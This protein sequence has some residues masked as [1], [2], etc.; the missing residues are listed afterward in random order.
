MK[1]KLLSDM[2]VSDGGVY[3]SSVDIDICYDKYGFPYIPAKRIRGCLREC[4]IELQDWFQIKEKTIRWKKMFGEE[5]CSTNRAAVRINDAHLEGY[6]EM[7]KLA[8]E[9]AG[10][11]VFHP[12]NILNHFTY[13]RT[14]TAINYE[15]GVAD[16]ASLRTMRVADKELVFEAEVDMDQAYK[17]EL[18]SCCAVFHSIGVSRTRG[19][20]EIQVTLEPCDSEQ[21]KVKHEPYEE[22]AEILQYQLFLEEPVICKSVNGGESRTLDYI[23]GSK[24]QGLLIEN[25]DSREEFLK[26][27]NSAELFC[28]NAYISQNHIRCTEVPSYIY[29]VKNDSA[30]YVNKLYPEP[31][32]V[33]EEALQLNAMK[34]CYISFDEKQR[35]HK[36]SVKIE[37]RYH[38]RRPEDKAAGRAA[39]E[40][41]GNS[42][43]YQM[44]SIEAGQSFQGYFA[45][46]PSQIKAIYEILSK[47]DTY[48]IGYSRTSEYGKVRLRITGTKKIEPS[49]PVRAKKFCVKME[50]PVIVYN[51]NAFYSTDPRDLIG[52]VNAVLGISEDI[53]KLLATSEEKQEE[54]SGVRIYARYTMSGGYNTTW[55]CPKP[56]IAAFDKG[57]VLLYS[58]KEETEL[59]IPPVLM[60]GERVSEGYG[61]A[62]IQILDDR[63]EI[64]ELLEIAEDKTAE[65]QGSVDAGKSTF[66][67]E[68]CRDLFK[69]YVRFAAAQEAQGTKKNAF[70]LGARP[71]VSN[72]L[73]MCQENEEFEK[74]KTACE[75]RYGKNT[76]K[77]QEKL[78]YAEKILKNVERC[79]EKILEEFCDTYQVENFKF[80][81]NEQ[82]MIY[83]EHFLKQL[84]Y[85]FRQTE[86]GGG[87]NE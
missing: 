41:S 26:I 59:T 85:N 37:E 8:E 74:V 31:V 75:E 27:M 17:E 87:E 21:I 82:K 86:Q 81:E 61:E 22:G 29:S 20:G 28:S 12:Q 16:K 77:K 2:C 47:Q 58:L 30:H 9:N 72:M 56:T 35:L 7:R 18:E 71:T 64:R 14:Q 62:S 80:S 78:E 11:T 19:L 66:I 10:K 60:I 44:S 34:H 53:D 73:L 54:E 3:N 70:G 67:S 42:Q 25:A 49:E 51:E 1:I 76:E 55:K 38:H 15:T 32:C 40:E 65:A 23:E 83:L 4:A 48:H 50:A 79:T 69:N 43:F 57:T 39:A 13:I 36:A 84:K 63:K 33:K 52:E 5:G 24:M 46:S 45:G 6:K 68:I